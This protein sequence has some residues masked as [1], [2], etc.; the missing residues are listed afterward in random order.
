MNRTDRIT[1]RSLD[2]CPHTLCGFYGNFHV[3]YI[4]HRIKYPE[5]IN[6]CRSRMF[7]EFDNN[8]IGIM[9]VAHK[10]LAAKEHLERCFLDGL[11]KSPEPVPRV[12]IKISYRRVKCCAPPHFK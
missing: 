1:D 6:A 8:I 4:V 5:N 11:L 7:H 9:P 10:V 12:F 3:P 2:M